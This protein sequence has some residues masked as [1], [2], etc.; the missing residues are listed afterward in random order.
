VSFFWICLIDWPHGCTIMTMPNFILFGAGRSGTTSMYHY[1]KH[2]PEIHLS[3]TKEPRFF[4]FEGMDLNFQG[5]GDEK[6]FNDS[7]L[8]LESYRTLFAGVKE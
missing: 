3:P 6:R 4:A 8:D 5:P 7:V 2:H 1:L